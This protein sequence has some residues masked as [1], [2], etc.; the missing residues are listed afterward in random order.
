[1]QHADRWLFLFSSHWT[2]RFVDGDIWGSPAKTTQHKLVL[3]G[4]HITRV[5]WHLSQIDAFCLLVLVEHERS[6]FKI[7]P[8]I[9]FLLFQPSK[10]FRANGQNVSYIVLVQKRVVCSTRENYCTFS[11]SRSIKKVYV[12]AVN[13]AGK[14]SPTVVQIYK[15]KGNSLTK[16]INASCHMT[17]RI[18]YASFSVCSSSCSIRCHSS[19]I[20]KQF[21]SC[22]VEKHG[23]LRTQR[24]CGKMETFV[25][26]RPLPHPV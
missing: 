22:S 20:W 2:P 25:K 5:A 16:Q 15:H 24:L 1:M 21:I 9:F 17:C 3:E 18:W 4:T 7:S 6:S 26:I 14:S 8:H 13:A 11:L 10:G 12:K 23:F 19:P